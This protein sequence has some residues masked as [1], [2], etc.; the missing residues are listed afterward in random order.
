MSSVCLLSLANRQ[1]ELSYKESKTE[2]QTYQTGERG[3]QRGKHHTEEWF[4]SQWR[5]EPRRSVVV[6]FVSQKSLSQQRL[7]SA[8]CIPPT[9]PFPVSLSFSF[10]NIHPLSRS[11]SLSPPEIIVY[12]D[13]QTLPLSRDPTLQIYSTFFT[14]HR[15]PEGRENRV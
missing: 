13:S 4:V 2:K 15:M 8:C 10:T 14:S 7:S 5:N 6:E 1:L 9:S 11:L 3:G 12:F